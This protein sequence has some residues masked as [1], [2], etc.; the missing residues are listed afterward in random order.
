MLGYIRKSKSNNIINIVGSSFRSSLLLLILMALSFAVYGA[1][2]SENNADHLAQSIEELSDYRTLIEQLEIER[3]N[4]LGYQSRAL[5]KQRVITL[6]AY[7]NL[8]WQFVDDIDTS[9]NTDIQQKYLPKAKEL[10]Q[11]ALEEIHEEIAMSDKL[12]ADLETQIID[13][14]KKILNLNQALAKERV[15]QL[16]WKLKLIRRYQEELFYAL[17]HTSNRAKTIQLNVSYALKVAKQKVQQQADTLSGLIGLNEDKLLQ[18]EKKKAVVRSE[19]STGEAL[20]SETALLNL[21]IQEYANRLQTQVTLLNDL[22]LSSALHKKTLIQTRDSVSS[23]ILDGKVISHLMTEWWLDIKTWLRRSAPSLLGSIITFFGILI[24]SYV[25]S[26]LGRKVIDISITRSRPDI[27]ALAKRFL[28]SS[29]GRLIFLIGIIYALAKLGLQIGPLLAGLGI[30]G[31]VIGFA[32]QE[33]LA[34]FASGL[35][36]LIYRPYDVGDK[37]QVAGINGRV[38]HMTLVTTTVFTSA[39]HHLTIPNNK[40]W[41][42]IINN[43]TSQALTRVDIFLTVPFNADSNM[44]L[45]AINDELAA[46]KVVNQD[47]DKQA[48]ICEL[49]ESALKYIARFWVASSDVD[50]AK[51]S[52]AEGIKVRFDE[53]GISRDIIESLD[54]K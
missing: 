7:R 28:I 2:N 43:V 21:E 31:F 16:Q 45:K 8:L 12:V 53:L 19:S 30:M 26:R 10:M 25:L 32:L 6:A 27:S 42:D 49:S 34:N 38:K 20:I 13:A 54:T 15:A 51:W 1:Q 9:T 35:M 46:N 50:E 37:I 11:Q 18:L 24:I 33:T 40:I 3:N 5:A 36:I 29:T 4:T 14:R 41:K 23:E 44:V 17:V 47:Q 39:N 22:G 52:I 48:R